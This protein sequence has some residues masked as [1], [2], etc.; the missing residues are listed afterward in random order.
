MNSLNSKNSDTG[1]N[2]FDLFLS[3]F[4]HEP[5]NSGLFTH[6][7]LVKD[8]IFLMLFADQ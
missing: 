2:F 3:D 4:G 1:I 6:K 7:Q 5:Q 8:F